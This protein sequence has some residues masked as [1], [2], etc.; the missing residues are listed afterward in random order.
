VDFLW[1]DHKLVAETDGR[2]THGTT[3]AFER[4]RA[5]DADLVAHGF[6]V[7]RFTYRQVAD[8]PTAV[9]QTLDRLLR[10]DLSTVWVA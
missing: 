1:S 4:D 5:R 10:G 2:V 8:T 6:R 7:V 3:A 9:A